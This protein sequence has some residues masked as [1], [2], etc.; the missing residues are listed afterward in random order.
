[1]DGLTLEAEMAMR[2]RLAR[3]DVLPYTYNMLRGAYRADMGRLLAEID[4]LR[5]QLAEERGLL[6]EVKQELFGEEVPADWRAAV[7]AMKSAVVGRAELQWSSEP[8]TEPGWYW[9]RESA[10]PI[11]PPSPVEVERDSRTGHLFH[12]LDSDYDELLAMMGGQW[13]P[14]PLEPP[15]GGVA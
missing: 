14:E 15:A 13:W 9:W 1:M 12:R 5:R 8:P 7:R 3:D 6:A 11:W 10:T 4:T 2:E